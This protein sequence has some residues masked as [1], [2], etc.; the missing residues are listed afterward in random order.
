MEM[1]FYCLKYNTPSQTM[2]CM[3]NI[4]YDYD[5]LFLH[6]YLQICVNLCPLGTGSRASIVIVLQVVICM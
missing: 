4:S 1:D 5:S 3:Q 6:F 2:K